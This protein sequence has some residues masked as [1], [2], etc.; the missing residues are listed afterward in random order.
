MHF[1]AQSHTRAEALDKARQLAVLQL[2]ALAGMPQEERSQL[3]NFQPRDVADHYAIH[4]GAGDRVELS[5]GTPQS[6]AGLLPD[7][8]DP[9]IELYDPHGA[10]VA[11]DDNSG[12]D[13]RNA[14]VGYTATEAG[15]YTVRVV[16]AQGSGEYLL[17]ASG[18]TAPRP[19]LIVVDSQP[20]PGAALENMPST[21]V[22][23]FSAPLDLATVAPGDLTVNG[24]PALDVQAVDGDSVRFVP[25]PAVNV[26]EGTYAIAIAAGS[27]SDLAGNTSEPLATT[28]TLDTTAPRILSTLWNGQPLPASRTFPGGPLAF[29]AVSSEPLAAANLN[30]AGPNPSD[31]MVH[32]VHLPDLSR[33]ALALF[34][35]ATRTITAPLGSLPEGDYRL[36]L[37]SGD[38]AFEDV[39]GNDL[40]GEANQATADGTVSGD[41]NDG[42]DFEVTFRVDAIPL[43]LDSRWARSAPAG[44]MV[45][46]TEVEDIVS[47]PRDVDTFTLHM[48]AGE[49]VALA[50]EPLSKD[51]TLSII[52]RS[53]DANVITQVTSAGPGQDLRLANVRADG[54][55]RYS[56]EITGDA[57]GQRFRLTATRNAIVEG[58]DT[59]IQSPRALDA[60]R[61]D[62]G[63][64]RSAATGSSVTA[65][66]RRIGLGCA[67]GQWHDRGSRSGHRHSGRLLSCP[68]QYRAGSHAD[69][70]VDGRTR[71]DTVVH[72]RGR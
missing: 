34:D 28:F 21:Y 41:G 69:R 65:D 53:P 54:S 55:G 68:R 38:E 22:V 48:Q 7:P 46:Q 13:G 40:D 31:A 29:T 26:G 50:L 1:A 24:Q 36:T 3:V 45:Y 57:I 17:R 32:N 12:P 11:E 25:D 30:P 51:N 72:Q 14:S 62:L 60:S 6:A 58:A 23:D 4:V 33:P 43:D 44:S 49:N 59:N 52:V 42:G 9:R 35:E 64:R 56:I 2:D 63:A 15:N 18:A 8:L 47:F 70:A 66:P 20:D 5:T 27:I 10:R 37:A 19:Q 67:A 39:V 71:T 61:V 16:A